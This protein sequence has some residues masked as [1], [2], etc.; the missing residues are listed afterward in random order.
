MRTLVSVSVWSVLVS[1]SPR[2]FVRARTM[3]STFTVISLRGAVS[4]PQ[5]CLSTDVTG[6]SELGAGR[7]QIWLDSPCSCRT[8]SRQILRSLP[9]AGRRGACMHA[10]SLTVRLC[11]TLWTVASQAPLS[12][13]FFRQE[14]WSGELFPSP[15]DLPNPGIEPASPVSSAMTTSAT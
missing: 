11:A 5:R 2:S 15:G 13:G 8:L 4:A 9:A 7:V 3:P 12:V 10:K 6:R 1:I 14:Y